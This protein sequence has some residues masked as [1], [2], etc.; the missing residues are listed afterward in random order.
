MNKNHVSQT[1]SPS[2]KLGSGIYGQVASSNQTSIPMN[3]LDMNQRPNDS[4][5][6]NFILETGVRPNLRYAEIQQ[7]LLGSTSKNTQNS[8][9]QVAS[10]SNI[11]SPQNSDK[12]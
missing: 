3:Q 8:Q 7:G 1:N 6:T 12:N 4:T 2:Q 11:G 9:I 5:Y 10:S